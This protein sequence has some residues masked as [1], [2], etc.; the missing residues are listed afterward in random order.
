M[1]EISHAD[2]CFQKE[3]RFPRFVSLATHLPSFL[4]GEEDFAVKIITFGNSNI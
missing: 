4:R 3:A 1:F 2:L